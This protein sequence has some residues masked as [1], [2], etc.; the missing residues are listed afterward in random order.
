LRAYHELAVEASLSKPPLPFEGTTL[1]ATDAMAMLTAGRSPRKRR[2]TPLPRSSFEIRLKF[3]G[4][5]TGPRTMSRRP[6][7]TTG[8]EGTRYQVDLGR[9]K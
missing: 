8:S 1:P 4:W 9:T 7:A 6:K 2:P 5:E 3:L